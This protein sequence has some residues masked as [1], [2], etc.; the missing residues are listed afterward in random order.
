LYIRRSI[1]NLYDSYL[2]KK[3]AVGNELE[4]ELESEIESEKVMK[5]IEKR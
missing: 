2:Q 1:E 5:I 3:S 4:N